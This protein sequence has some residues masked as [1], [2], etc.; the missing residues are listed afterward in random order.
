GDYVSFNQLM[1]GGYVLSGMVEQAYGKPATLRNKTEKEVLKIDERVNICYLVLRGGFL[2]IFPIP[3]DVNHTWISL[4]DSEN[5]LP[6]ENREFA[7]RTLSNYQAAVNEAKRTGNWTRAYELL[8]ELKDYQFRHGSS[9]IPTTARVKLEIFYINNNIFNNLARFYLFTGLALLLLAFLDIF[10]AELKIRKLISTGAILVI[11]LFIFHTL[12]LAMRWYI[13]GHAPW[14]NGY[15]SMIFIGWATCLSGLVF[16][17]RSLMALAVTTILAAIVLLVAGLS[18]MSPVI[19]NLVP[20]LKS[21]WLI[22]HVAIVT[23]SYGFFGISA[24]L[25]LANLI[26]LTLRRERNKER[27]TLTI[28]E[29][30]LIIEIALIIGLYM[31]TIGS[32]IGGVW[33]NE[34]WGRYWGWDP[35]ETWALVTILVYAFIVHM[36]KIP[37]FKGYFQVSTAALLGFF[38]VLMT[39]FG[40]NYYFS[41]LHSYASGESAPVPKGVYVAILIILTVIISAFFSWKAAGRKADLVDT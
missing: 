22:V 40:V 7:I 38:S 30:A 20:V 29:L 11:T 33:A 36:H 18:W 17:R 15:E 16:A 19:T 41:G 12:G 8:Y 24:M 32:F 23:A 1:S 6:E 13:A 4:T 9:V 34:S 5:I 14:S 39:Y 26:L 25:G 31:L 28:K 3:G 35:K 10:K 37:G 21:Y 2:K 27:V